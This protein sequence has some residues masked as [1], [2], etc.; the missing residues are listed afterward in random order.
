MKNKVEWQDIVKVNGK[1]YLERFDVEFE[2]K[3][4]N[5]WHFEADEEL[6]INELISLE[7]VFN[8][9]SF[10]NN[11]FEPLYDCDNFFNSVRKK[12]GLSKD[13]YIE[14]YLFDHIDLPDEVFKKYDIAW[15]GGYINGVNI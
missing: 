3:R 9:F 5:D 10:N 8:G 11:Y 14:T 2:D 1:Y 7:N 4:L 13:D 15:L 12:Y 6:I